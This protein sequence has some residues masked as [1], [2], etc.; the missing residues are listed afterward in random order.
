MFLFLSARQKAKV[1]D[2]VD[3]INTVVDSFCGIAPKLDGMLL[4]N[5]NSRSGIAFTSFLI[6]ERLYYPLPV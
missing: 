2:C 3:V 4:S 6:A 1:A 5:V